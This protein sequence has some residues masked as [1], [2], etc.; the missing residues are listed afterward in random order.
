MT[1]TLD[2]ERGT[3]THNSPGQYYENMNCCALWDI[4]DDHD[5]S[6]DNQDTL[7]DTSLSKIWAVMRDDK[8]DD[9][10]GFWNSWFKSFQYTDEMTRIFQDHRIEH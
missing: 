9:I 6:A 4:F 2:L 8:P 1:Y 10:I 3:N 7:S 5:D